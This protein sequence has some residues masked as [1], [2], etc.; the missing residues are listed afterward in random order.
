MFL[1]SCGLNLFWNLSKFEDKVTYILRKNSLENYLWR[2]YKSKINT[3][4]KRS[5]LDFGF[6]S[7]EVTSLY[8]FGVM[9]CIQCANRTRQNV[10][11]VENSAGSCYLKMQQ[12]VGVA[13]IF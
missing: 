3:Y 4:D 6:A 2:R 9:N 13:L 5:Y 1:Y 12:M 7:D 8:C 10:P 11:V